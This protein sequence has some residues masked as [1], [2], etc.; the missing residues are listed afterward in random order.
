MYEAAKICETAFAVTPAPGVDI[1]LPTDDLVMAVEPKADE[2]IM[3]AVDNNLKCFPVALAHLLP[4][5]GF[6]RRQCSSRRCE[7]PLGG[8][9]GVF[10]QNFLDPLPSGTQ[11][12]TSLPF[13]FNASGPTPAFGWMWRERERPF[14]V[15]S[16]TALCALGTAI[17]GG[18]V[19]LAHH[20]GA[21]DSGTS[22]GS[23]QNPQLQQDV[24]G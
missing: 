22:P 24:D 3:T 15:T 19:T 10:V 4:L 13:P 20:P 8:I 17:T 11:F 21:G 9:S 12:H 5:P 16:R 18:Q 7:A 6:D 23:Q 14:S 2:Q 1:P